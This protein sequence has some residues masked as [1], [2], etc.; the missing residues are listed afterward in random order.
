M[1]VHRAFPLK[2]RKARVP[3]DPPAKGESSSKKEISFCIRVQV[4]RTLRLKEY[5][6]EEISACWHS[7]EEIEKSR[8]DIMEEIDAIQGGAIGMQRGLEGQTVVGRLW[9]KAMGM[10]AVLAV[11]DEQQYQK[12]HGYRNPD[13]IARVYALASQESRKNARTLGKLDVK[14][15]QYSFKQAYVDPMTELRARTYHRALHARC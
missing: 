10:R 11:C 7:R 12:E 2:L 4:R 14:G 13:A 9:R 3:V 5:T 15:S 1:T 8:E 6:E